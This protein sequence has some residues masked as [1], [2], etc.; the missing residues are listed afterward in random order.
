MEFMPMVIGAL[1]LLSFYIF[2]RKTIRVE[3]DKL[4]SFIAFM[5]LVT[6]LRIAMYDLL[7]RI[8]PTMIPTMHRELL[9]IPKIFLTLVWW[10]DCS[11]FF[12]CF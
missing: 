9:E 11:M 8:D 7:M 1:M 4:A 10:E 3:W 12:Q 6:F 5:T 2:D